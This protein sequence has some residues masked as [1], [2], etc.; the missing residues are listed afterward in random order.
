M[1]QT[2]RLLEYL[3]KHERISLIGCIRSLGITNPSA[4]VSEI[5]KKYGKEVIKTGSVWVQSNRGEWFKMPE[6]TITKQGREKIWPV[7]KTW[8]EWLSIVK[9]I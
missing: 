5:R 9:Q 3:R 7:K 8:P 4:I 6:Y 2:A 1:T